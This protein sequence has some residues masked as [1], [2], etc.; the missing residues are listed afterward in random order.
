LA[1]IVAR[2]G[3]RQAVRSASRANGRYCLSVMATSGI[4]EIANETDMSN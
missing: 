3:E 2:K 1:E 4:E